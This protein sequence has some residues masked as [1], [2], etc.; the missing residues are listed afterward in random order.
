MYRI[1]QDTWTRSE[2]LQK[3]NNVDEI[4][5]PTD[6]RS[7]EHKEKE[8]VSMTTSIMRNGDWVQSTKAVIIFPTTVL[9]DWFKV[10]IR[11]PIL[12]GVEEFQEK[13]SNWN[14]QSIIK[15]DINFYKYNPKRASSSI[16]LRTLY[17][18]KGCINVQSDNDECFKWAILSGLRPVKSHSNRATSYVKF[19]F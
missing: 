6:P 5:E 14:L 4:L 10:N 15:F 2:N 12:H 1:N 19:Q 16:Q 11:H 13:G 17:N 8:N 9:D 7:Y 3:C 18:K